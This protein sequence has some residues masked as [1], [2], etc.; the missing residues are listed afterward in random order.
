MDLTWG[1]LRITP[2]QPSTRYQLFPQHG[3]D[4]VVQARGQ[5]VLC[6]SKLNSLIRHYSL[7]LASLAK[8]SGP[9]DD[10]PFCGYS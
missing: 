6:H 2:R 4:R 7:L 10:W 1:L 5:R 9:Q 3:V 8:V